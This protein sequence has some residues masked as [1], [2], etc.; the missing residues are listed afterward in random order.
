MATWREV[1]REV[2]AAADAIQL[3]PSHDALKIMKYG[4]IDTGAGN[5]KKAFTAWFFAEGD[6]RHIR[7]YLA[8]AIQFA[9]YNE[10]FTLDQLKGIVRWVDQASTFCNYCGFREQYALVQAVF[11]ALDDVKTK[12]D[13]VELIKPLRIYFSHMNMW[14]YHYFPYAIGCLM[15]L[16]DAEYFKEGLHLTKV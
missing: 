13:L 8:Y 12:E 3:E 1:A 14:S 10:T 5:E 7:D 16:Q 9:R 11:D 2:Q 4:M 15:P 6:L